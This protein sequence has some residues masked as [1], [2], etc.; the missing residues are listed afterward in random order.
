MYVRVII[1][2]LREVFIYGDGV[3]NTNSTEI[4]TQNPD[5]HSLPSEEEGL[6]FASELGLGSEEGISPMQ[7]P[8]AITSTVKIKSRPYLLLIP[9]I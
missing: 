3:V 1:K 4:S 2:A 5:Q 8:S 6:F 9:E 7:V